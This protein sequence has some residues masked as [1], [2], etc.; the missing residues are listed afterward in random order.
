ML[1]STL[2]DFKSDLLSGKDDHLDLIFRYNRRI[3]RELVDFGEKKQ[4]PEYFGWK[5]FDDDDQ[6]E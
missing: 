5:S 4:L 6:S 3:A 2:D 1:A